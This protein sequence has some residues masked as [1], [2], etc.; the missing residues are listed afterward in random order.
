MQ[1]VDWR[2]YTCKCGQWVWLSSLVGVANWIVGVVNQ[3][4]NQFGG[5]G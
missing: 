5:C 4:G 1:T 2:L 3:W